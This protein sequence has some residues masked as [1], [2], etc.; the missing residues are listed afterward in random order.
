MVAGAK[1][2]QPT[3]IRWRGSGGH[4]PSSPT[5]RHKPSSTRY[6]GGRRRRSLPGEPG[7]TR[8]VCDDKA[9]HDSRPEHCAELR[10]A[11]RVGIVDVGQFG[12]DQR[13]H[14]RR[15]EL[16]AGDLPG[17]ERIAIADSR[18]PLWWSCSQWGCTVGRCYLRGGPARA[19][20]CGH[21]RRAGRA[22]VAAPPHASRA[23][24]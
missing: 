13:A 14:P 18:M 4:E 24:R 1:Q 23:G 22:W 9:V 19:G 2:R 21:A 15:A 20:A 11:A 10:R 7:V 17:R 8:S 5:M 16:G 6:P 3:A 12:A